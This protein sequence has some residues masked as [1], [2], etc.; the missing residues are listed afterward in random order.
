MK[1]KKS[2]LFTAR[3]PVGCFD[4]E[5]PSDSRL[6]TDIQILFFETIGSKNRFLSVV[7]SNQK[8]FCLTFALIAKLGPDSGYGCC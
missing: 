8:S 5:F 6:K 2:K 7:L 3:F 1:S 4:T